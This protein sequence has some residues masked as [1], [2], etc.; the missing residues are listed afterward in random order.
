MSYAAIKLVHGP[1]GVS[2]CASAFITHSPVNPASSSGWKSGNAKD[3]LPNLVLVKANV[4]E[5][6]NVRFQEG[7]E[8]SARG[9]EQLVGSACVAFPASAKR[10]GFMSGI[11]AAWLELVCQYR[12]FGIVDSMAILHRGRDGGRHRDAIILAFP[13]AKFS[14]LF[15][16]DATQQLKTSSMHYFEGPEWIHLK[17]GREKFPGGPLVRADSQGRCAG[18]LIYKSQLVMMKAAQEA[19]GL[20]EEDDP[21]GN[22]VSARIESSYVVNLQE[23]GMMHVKDFVFLYGYIEPVVAILHER[24]LTWAG[25]VT[26]RRDTCCVTAL[27]IN[28]NTKKHP[29]LWFQTGLP[30]DAYSLLAVPSPIGGVLVLCANSI[31]YYSQVSTCIVAVN[32]LA[33]PPAGS[34]EMPRSKFSIELDAA[35]ATWLSYDAA[36]LSTKTGML[37]HLHLIFDG[38]NV[39]RLELSKSKGSVLSSSLCTI[40]DMFFFVGSRLGD[41]LLV[42]F[43]SASTSNSLSQSYDGEDDIMVRPSKRMRLDDDA[44]EQSLYQYKSA[45][46][47][48]QKNMNFLFSVRDSLCNIGPIR[49]I[50]GRSQNPSEQPGSAQDLIACC[51]HGKNGSLNIISRSIRPDFITQAN[52]SL[53]FFAVAYALFF[54]VKLPGCVGVW[55]VYHRSGQIPAEKDEYHAYLIISLESR[56]MVLETGETLGEVTDS[57]EYYTEGPSIS[58]GNLFGR[59][60]IAQVYQ[61]GVRIL[62][63]ARQTQDLQVGEPG[64]AIESASF[65][66]PYVLLRMQDGS[67]QLVVGDSE[68]LTVS[69]ST[70]PELGLSPDPI[71]ACT[72]YND[73]GPSP[74]LRR[75]TGDVWQT[76]GVPDANF[77]FD[78]GDMYCIVCRNSGTMEF[79]ELPSMACLYRV[80]RLP[81]GVQVLADNRTASKV[82][83]DTSS[84]KDEEGAEEIR[85]RMSKIKVVDICVDTWGEKYGRPFVFVLLSDG[86]LLS[87]RAFIYEGQDSGAHASDGTS[88]RNLRFLR[89]QLDLELGEEDSNADEVRSVQKIIPFK[90]VG[91]LQGL[92]LAGGKPTWLMIFREQIRL[93]PQASDGPIVAFTSLHNVNCQHGLI[94]VT[95]EASL[96]I[97]RLSNIL[98][99]DNDWPVQKIPLKGTPHQMAHHPDLNIYVLVLSFSVSV[100]TSLV[101][102]SAADGPP[103]HQIDQSEASDGLDP[104]KMVQVDDFEVRLLEPMA[105]GVP[106]ET[107][108]TIKFQPAE[109][110]LTVR[111]VSIKNAATEQVEN[112]LAIGTGYLQGEDVASRGRIILVS[113]GEDP[114]DPKVWA[115]ELYSKELKGAISA[116]AALQGHLL[117]AI[118]PK[119]I[120]HTWNGSELI[121]TAFF[122]APLYVVSLNIVKNFVLFGDFHKSI[123]F[124]CWKEEGAQ[125]VLLAKDFGSLDCYATE[126]LIDGS[127]LSL[128]VSD[129]RKNIQVFSYAP[130][131]AESWKGQKLLPRVE[132]HLGSHVT[133]F[134][135]LQML[136]TPGSSRTNRFALCFGTLDGGIGYITPLDEL[137]FRRLQTLQRKLV[138]LVPHVAGLNPKAY[139]Q[140]QANGE[141]HKHGPDNTVDSEQLR[142]YESLSLDKQVAI[143]RQIGTTRQQIFANLRDISLSTSFF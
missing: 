51:G 91:G 93:H 71:S 20:V 50:T 65:A 103:G 102:P 4:L 49:D 59:R 15:F 104:Q 40:G 120:L 106:W 90:D 98:N 44:N 64:N 30:Y 16:D 67:C 96:K 36:L 122:D 45:V 129:S 58:A 125:L 61:K 34:L 12:L 113:L 28:T 138:D 97:C 118:G 24:E 63:G 77:A 139:R 142:E 140:F 116:L 69:V 35:H 135:R 38:R 87:Y 78:Q 112:L 29:R 119:I 110:V 54:Q 137:T 9:G 25:R 107:K 82:P 84:N 27:S 17:R 6:Y 94:Y 42:Q 76:L 18:V 117:L 132:F 100:P 85:E 43:G 10:G 134:L 89:L 127:T 19:Y 111:I 128:L 108:D 133:K 99:Y 101:L 79:L 73:R 62:D 130:K 5:I 72:L 41:S 83:V 31:L 109:N 70:P 2:A 131:N 126:F 13:A 3:S 55:T 1:T 26:F 124:L 80:E 115:K 136:Q 8:K 23:L 95:N 33:T 60:R 105:Q 68:T 114:S 56:T 141:H 121:G 22:I 86:T 123:Y 81:Y 92:F 32:E 52:M 143:A 7:D 14:V 47:D 21:S 48:S 11:T 66:D 46:S 53:L 75:A 88:F 74:W 37:V 57:V 39:Q